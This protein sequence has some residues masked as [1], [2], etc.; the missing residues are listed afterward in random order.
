M[1]NDF[2]AV[3]DS[4]MSEINYDEWADY[5]HRQ[6]LNMAEEPKK[7]I[8]FGCGT[9]NI[10]TRLAKKGY[11]MTAVDISEEMLTVA[12]EKADQQHLNVRFYKGDM[13][14][15]AIAEQFDAVISACDSVNYLES[16]E[17]VAGFVQ[18]AYEAL[19]PG[20]ELL[21]D[22]N[23]VSKFKN[24]IGDNTFIYDV[25]DAYCVWENDPVFAQDKIKYNLTF[26]VK[27]EDGRYDRF[28]EQQVQ[29]IYLAGDIY[30]LLKQTGFKDIKIFN[31]GTFLAGSDENDRLQFSAKKPE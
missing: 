15:F 12:D 26:F 2:A 11:D 29:Y 9:G 28:E 1:Y 19:K 8:E 4:L 3:Y 31:F 6:F 23:T 21:F 18:G 5:L 22:M 25:E 20:G 27:G 24:V 17:D 13:S 14:N 16:L 10:T 30:R 7:I